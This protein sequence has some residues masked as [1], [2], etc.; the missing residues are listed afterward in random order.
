MPFA[1]L[2]RSV[3]LFVAVL[4]CACGGP[5]VTVYRGATTQTT[6]VGGQSTTRT[7]QG[8]AYT[9]VAGND[10]NT[11]IIETGGTAFTATRNNDALT[12]AGGQSVTVTETNAMSSTS[13]TS[14]TG[15]LTA[16]SLTMNL[17]LTSSQTQNGMTANGTVM[18]QFTGQRL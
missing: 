7:T 11:V 9:V 1:L 13:L 6:N 5:P 16:T 4:T 10:P 18:L 15:T 12:F 14:G 3:V 17:T 8:D 2:T